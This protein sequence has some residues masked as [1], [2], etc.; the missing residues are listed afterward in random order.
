M[1]VTKSQLRR[2]IQESLGPPT[3]QSWADE[4]GFTIDIDPMTG[5][6]VVL[7]SDE[8]AMQTGLPDGA[9]WG[10]ER[11]YDDDG[12]IVSPHGQS[13]PEFEEI[14]YGDLDA[15]DDIGIQYRG[16]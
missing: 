11:S 2:I 14:A 1:R 3:F 8:F 6:K 15:M 4:N 7:I 9:D 12:W 13:E 16:Y 5:E 10:V